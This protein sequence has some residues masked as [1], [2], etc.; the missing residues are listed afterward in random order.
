MKEWRTCFNEEMKGA[1]YF[2]SHEEEI[3]LFHEGTLLEGDI[4]AWLKKHEVDKAQ[5]RKALKVAGQLIRRFPNQI[6]ILAKEI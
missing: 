1:P 3:V 2:T 5:E 4:R 6:P